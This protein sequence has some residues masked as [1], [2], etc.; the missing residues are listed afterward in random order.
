VNL[1]VRQGAHAQRAQRDDKTNCRL[2]CL[3]DV[4]LDGSAQV[5]R[6]SSRTADIRPI[7]PSFAAFDSARGE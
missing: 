4:L 6:E 1:C 3:H 7:C 5:S 2:C